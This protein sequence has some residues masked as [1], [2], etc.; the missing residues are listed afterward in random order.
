M[1]YRLVD[2]AVEPF[3]PGNLAHIQEKLAVG[4]GFL[5]WHGA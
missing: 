4:Y 5:L 2:P 3:D 1:A